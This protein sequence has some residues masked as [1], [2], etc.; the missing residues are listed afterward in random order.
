M[1]AQQYIISQ[2]AKLR[3]PSPLQIAKD[4]V[5]DD[6]IV[7]RILSK[8]FR[9]YAA[10]SSLVEHINYVVRFAIRND[11]PINFTFLHGAYKLWRL[12]EA[13]Y[14]DWAEMFALMYYIKWL[15]PIC[16]AYRPGVQLDFFV[17]DIILERLNNLRYAE[18]DAYISSYQ[19]LIGFLADYAPSNLAITITPVSTQ[20]SSD[21]VF[22]KSLEGNLSGLSERPLPTLSPEKAATIELNVR[23]T[24]EQLRDPLWRER[25]LQLHNAYMKT[26]GETGY[27]KN[28]IDKILVF[29]QPLPSGTALAVG[30]TKDSV[31]KFWVGAGALR[32]SDVSFRMTIMSPQQLSRT[33]WSSESV[34]ITGL[35]GNNFSRIRVVS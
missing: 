14:V 19:S 26:K 24:P 5:L 22:W 9:K 13:P 17:D 15:R 31:V 16:E 10:S 33:K 7:R 28:R 29:T 20:F 30:S 18:I 25:N 32:R 21:S 11:Q 35:S 3:L 23:A 12:E 6:A 1:N 8:K 2:L 27:H 34:A 4:E